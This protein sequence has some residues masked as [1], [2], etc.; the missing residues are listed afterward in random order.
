MDT[1]QNTNMLQHLLQVM[2]TT[3]PKMSRQAMEFYDVKGL[4]PV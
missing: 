1:S 4:L 2:N 3:S